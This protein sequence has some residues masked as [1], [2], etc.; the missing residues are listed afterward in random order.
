MRKARPPSPAYD[1]TYRQERNRHDQVEANGGAAET[2][3][4]GYDDA[5]G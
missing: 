3:V 1:Y 4:Y 2:T 5:T